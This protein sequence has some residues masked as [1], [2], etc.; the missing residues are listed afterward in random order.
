MLHGDHNVDTVTAVPE[1]L[2]THSDASIPEHSLK[3]FRGCLIALVRNFVVS[4]GLSNGSLFIVL[5]VAQH[6]LRILNINPESEHYGHTEVLYRFKFIVS[7]KNKFDFSRIQFPV[8]VAYG[9]SVHKLQGYSVGELGRLLLD[10]RY[11]PFVHAQSYV[12]TSRA[13][14][15]NQVILLFDH[16]DDMTRI[17]SLCYGEFARFRDVIRP[18]RPT[19]PTNEEDHSDR[20]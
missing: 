16:V 12:A 14:R 19:Q 20:R 4:R 1:V 6:Y 3:L 10:L 7:L 11:C 15:S 9:C 2:A 8:R 5:D 17:Q 13:R 18:S